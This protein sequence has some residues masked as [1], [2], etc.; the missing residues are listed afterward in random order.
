MSSYYFY[1]TRFFRR[2]WTPSPSFLLL[3]IIP[4]IY[5]ICYSFLRS[6][7]YFCDISY[8]VFFSSITLSRSS[9]SF[10]CVVCCR[11]SMSLCFW[12]SFSSRSCWFSPESAE[13]FLIFFCISSWSLLRV[14]FSMVS[15][16]SLNLSSWVVYSRVL[17]WVFFFS[18]SNAFYLNFC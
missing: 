5:S 10:C 9:Y 1:L 6:D 2:C 17:I 12:L 8:W 15:C 4:F 3:F 14:S 16:C 7:F 18:C 11:D 13:S